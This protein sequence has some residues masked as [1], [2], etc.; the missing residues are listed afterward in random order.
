MQSYKKI[1]LY[2]FLYENN[3]IFALAVAVIGKEMLTFRG[4]DFASLVNK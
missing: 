4:I 2:F 3:S 1:N